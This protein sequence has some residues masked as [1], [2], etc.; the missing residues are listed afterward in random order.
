MRKTVTGTTSLLKLT[1][2]LEKAKKWC[3][4]MKPVWE[5]FAG[6]NSAILVAVSLRS[7]I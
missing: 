4:V 6:E 2:H 1:P 3:A 7:H 5:K